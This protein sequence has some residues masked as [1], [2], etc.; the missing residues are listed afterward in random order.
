[1]KWLGKKPIKQLSINFDYLLKIINLQRKHT[2]KI[3]YADYTAHQ[4]LCNT[5]V[6][7]QRWQKEC[8]GSTIFFFLWLKALFCDI[9]PHAN[10]QI[11]KSQGNN[12]RWLFCPLTTWVS[13]ADAV[14]L[15]KKQQQFG[16]NTND[17]KRENTVCKT[18][19][20]LQSRH[21][22]SVWKLWEVFGQDTC[23]FS[24]SFFVFLLLV[25]LLTV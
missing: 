12:S 21:Q 9:T 2:V 7:L 23:Y 3:Y 13:A 24:A 15:L 10:L 4:L 14:I 5:G 6:S 16:Y 22:W 1:M 25:K 17:T 20:G 11:I 18:P 19:S 8:Q